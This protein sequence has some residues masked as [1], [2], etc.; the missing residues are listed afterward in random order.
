MHKG[1]AQNV[2]H[3]GHSCEAMLTPG[4]ASKTNGRPFRELARVQGFAAYCR[5]SG[6]GWAADLLQFLARYYFRLA[7]YS[8]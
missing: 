7:A 5:L 2:V 6:R 8:D 4:A 1:A 3:V